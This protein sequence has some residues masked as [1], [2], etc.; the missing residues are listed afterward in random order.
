MNGSGLFG[1]CGD[2]DRSGITVI[3]EEAPPDMSLPRHPGGLQARGDKSGN[4]EICVRIHG[5]IIT[6]AL[7]FTYTAVST[8]PWLACRNSRKFGSRARGVPGWKGG[9]G[10]MISSYGDPPSKRS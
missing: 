5:R 8:A 4:R 9:G 3:Y 10:M 6:L 2:S 7:R 1:V